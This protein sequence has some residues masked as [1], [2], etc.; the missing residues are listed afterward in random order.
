MTLRD[1][2]NLISLARMLLVLPVVLVLAT[3]HYGAAL[4]LFALAGASDALDGFLAKRFGWTSRVGAI[5]DPLA[6]KVLLVSTY[7]ALGWLGLLPAWLVAAVIA[8]DVVIVSGAVTYHFRIGR[9]ETA[10]TALSKLNTFV[11]ILLALLVV[12]A[13]GGAPVPPLWI[14]GL[15]YLVLLTTVASGIVYVWTWGGRAWRSARGKAG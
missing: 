12:S 13:Q 4:A 3:G 2:P 7:L 6:D 8:R 9:F 11:Q 14:T 5:L 15:I 10:P 1:L